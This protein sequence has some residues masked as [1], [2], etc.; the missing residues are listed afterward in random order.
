MKSPAQFNGRHTIKQS[1]LPVVCGLLF[2]VLAL[3]FLAS[4]PAQIV[5]AAAPTPTPVAPADETFSGEAPSSQHSGDCFTC[6]GK[7]N[8][9]G[10]LGDGQEVNLSIDPEVSQTNLHYRLGTCAICHKNYEGYPHPNSTGT[11][12]SK[13]H[14][15]G[16]TAAALQVALPYE[17][18]REMVVDLNKRC[19]VCHEMAFLDFSNGT[20]AKILKSNNNS[21]PLCSDCHGS[22]TI[23]HVTKDLASQSCA[24]CHAATYTSFQH[25]VH[26]AN[27]AN[28]SAEDAL[29]CITCHGSHNMKGPS[30]VD[31]RKESVTVC[32]SCHEDQALMARYDLPADIF[33]P[34]IDNYHTVDVNLTEKDLDV[35]GNTP[36]CYDC[37]GVHTIHASEDLGSLV[38]EANLTE[39]CLK[40]HAGDSDFTVA[41]QAHLRSSSTSNLGARVIQSIFAFLTPISAGLLFVFIGLD[42]RKWWTQRN[43]SNRQGK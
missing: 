3:G 1:I 24:Q 16:D 15:A 38:N 29:T 33:D 12:C 40:C 20:H 25:S 7:P 19:Y 30:N 9:T 39:T 18:T 23:Q 37:H 28:Q 5:R 8:F 17:N 13:C 4:Q 42:V 35:T 10:M 21:A 41:G 2:V 14:F 26:G 43:S 6:H 31:F 11:A 34:N 36:V 27:L 32:L 22:H